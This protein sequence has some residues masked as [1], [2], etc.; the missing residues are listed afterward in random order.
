MEY[1]GSDAH[2]DGLLLEEGDG[3]L[4]VQLH[5]VLVVLELDF[6]DVLP[7]VVLLVLAIEVVEDAPHRGLLVQLDLRGHVLLLVLVPDLHRDHHHVLVL[8]DPLEGLVQLLVLGTLGRLELRVLDQ[9]ELLELR[10]HDQPGPVQSRKAHIRL[11]PVVVVQD[12]NLVGIGRVLGELYEAAVELRVG[13]VGL[14][15]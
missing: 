6:G 12:S 13:Q 7:G 9:R 2:D 5:V 8:R 11:I 1:W 10:L 3:H 14:D 15:R 4:L